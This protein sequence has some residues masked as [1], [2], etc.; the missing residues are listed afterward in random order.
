MMNLLKMHQPSFVLAAADYPGLIG[1]P[2][3]RCSLRFPVTL[4][5]N[6]WLPLEKRLGMMRTYVVLKTTG[7]I[8]G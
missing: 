3:N 5:A 7:M 2:S 1:R 8:Y 4:A 6:D